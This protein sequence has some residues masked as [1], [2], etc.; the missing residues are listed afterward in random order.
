M[1]SLHELFSV[2]VAAE[3]VPTKDHD[4]HLVLENCVVV[5]DGA[6]PLESLGAADSDSVRHLARQVADSIGKSAETDPVKRFL[7]V[8]DIC[9]TSDGSSAVAAAVWNEGDD[10]VGAVVGDCVIAVQTSDGNVTVTF[11]ET[12]ARLDH[13]S[14]EAMYKRDGTP[15]RDDAAKVLVSNRRLLNTPDGYGAFGP[16]GMTSEHVLTIRYRLDDVRRILLC[17]DGYW[18]AI[19]TY[20]LFPDAADLI[21]H[22]LTTVINRIRAVEDEDSDATHFPRI[23]PVDDITAVL[24]ERK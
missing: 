21:G 15:H 19:D 16:A 11:D 5:V 4:S 7:K 23:S 20:Q 9:T 2:S 14:I 6:T 13:I 1:R 3:P 22:D 24:L 17:S 18:R 12:L 8:A 10:L